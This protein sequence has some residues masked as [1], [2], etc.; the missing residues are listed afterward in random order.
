MNYELVKSSF[1]DIERLIKY[2]KDTIYAYAD[3]LSNDEIKEID[4]YVSTNVPL[5]LNDYFNIV[6]DGKIIGCV[7]LTDMDD[8][9]LLDEIYLEEDYRGKGIGSDIIKN[10]LKE[11]SVLY[12]WVYKAN[13]KAISLYKRLGFVVINETDS[14]YYMKYVI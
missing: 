9:K 5:F 3:N 4:S 13:V 7:L 6:S 14:R 1:D 11:N 10:I 12:L 2:K 8:G